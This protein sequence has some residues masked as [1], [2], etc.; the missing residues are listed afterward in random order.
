[1]SAL[2]A[3]S[4]AQTL[5]PLS[6]RGAWTAAL[7]DMP[8]AFGHTWES[9]HAFSL[10]SGYP[11]FLYRYAVGS[12]RVVAPVAERRFGDSTDVVSPYGCAGFSS[13]GCD[14]A[15][16][17]AWRAFAAARGWVCG[18][19]LQ[20]PMIAPPPVP[21]GSPRPAER[22]SYVLDLTLDDAELLRRMAKKRRHQV[23]RS[24]ETA[25]RLT[26][27][28]EL[29]LEFILAERAAFFDQRE[30]A[31][32]YFFSDATWSALARAPNTELIGKVRDGR[33]VAMSLLARQGERAEYLFNISR[34]E[35]RNESAHL[36]WE[37]ARRMRAAGA[38][39]LHLGG[40]V[41]E[42]DGVASFKER[43]GP[44]RRPLLGLRQIYDF[45]R[46]QELCRAAGV[47][48]DADG[49]F[50]PYRAGTA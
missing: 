18:Y 32:I 17:E 41:R 25:A 29:L 16:A 5:I 43:F 12:C 31:S 15:F 42:G 1:M 13:V 28:R 14:G 24:E 27:D 50:P 36:V 44:D 3:E 22:T 39:S 23:R 46:Y 2:K 7:R 8:H 35:G 20:H 19:F 49:Y 26:S 33:V 9:C 10:S 38:T 47:A 40:G 48:P 21:R 34:P 6:D 30:A 4:S 45:R 37:A 11:T